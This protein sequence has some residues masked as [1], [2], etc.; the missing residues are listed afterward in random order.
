MRIEN[1][2]RGAENFSCKTC[3]N[4]MKKKKNGKKETN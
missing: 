3:K 4:N 1:G 2:A